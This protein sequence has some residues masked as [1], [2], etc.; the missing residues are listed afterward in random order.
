M[1]LAEALQERADLNRKV[2]ELRSRIQM[3]VL[4]QE[5]EQPSEQ[6]EALM[7][8]LESALARLEHLM[9]AINLTNCATKVEDITITELI[10]KRDTLQLKLSAYKDIVYSASQSTSR[11]RNSAIR[12]RPV[13]N[14]PELQRKVDAG[15]KEL[16]LLDNKLQQTNWLVDLIEA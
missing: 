11:A 1:K 14:V 16:R 3:N 2:A 12:I 8:E 9:A 6:P 5:D 15:A 10:A 13:V 7:A 4:V